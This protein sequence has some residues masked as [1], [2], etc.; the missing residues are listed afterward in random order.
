MLCTSEES[1]NYVRL[2]TSVHVGSNEEDL[3]Y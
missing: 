2:H 3:D 1:H